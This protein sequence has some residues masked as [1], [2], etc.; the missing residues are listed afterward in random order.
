MKKIH[1]KYR[2]TRNNERLGRPIIILLSVICIVLS[3]P[4]TIKAKDTER[5][6]PDIELGR[7]VFEQIRPHLKFV[8]NPSIRQY[9]E[10][11]GSRITSTLPPN[12]YEFR[13]FPIISKEINAFALSNGYIFITDQLIGACDSEDELA[14][15]L[16]HEI[17]HVIKEHLLN[18]L[19]QKQKIDFATVAIMIMGALLAKD[20]D[21]QEGI[22][23]ISLGMNENLTL[24]YS[25]EQETEAD[26]YGL[27][28]LNQA[29]YE[30]S[31]APQFMEK[32]RLLSQITFYPPPYLSTHPM[33][34]DRLM[35][36]KAL[37]SSLTPPLL[38]PHINDFERIKLWIQ[39][40]TTFTMRMLAELQGSYSK[41]PDNINTIYGLALVNEKLGA[42]EESEKFYLKGIEINP[43]DVDILRDYA[44]FLYKRGKIE[45]AKKRLE[46][47]V[48][49]SNQD[50]ISHYY[51]GRLL[52]D[53]NMP[54][55]A[56]KSL[57]KS[58]EIFPAFEDNYYFLGMAYSKI[59]NE[60][61]SHEYFKK[62]FSLIGN[63]QAAR[64]HAQKRRGTSNNMHE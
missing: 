23:A 31:G 21:L 16:S 45:K 34:V 42:S 3:V 26:T 48:K 27:K 44:I 29:G 18:F 59:G 49:L 52:I 37:Q 58:T 62:Y 2:Q 17:T 35:K 6:P 20:A 60:G 15:V 36:L 63:K 7:E 50:F 64:L 54:E 8:G 56:I 39:M 61:K 28:F 55:D 4:A 9:I 12:K 25:R 24:S 11:V 22:P 33:P 1:L 51:L 43:K 32:L 30:S 57:Q 19:S 53:Q 5:L 46:T 41:T 40:E 10:K 14:F 47:A 13:F 38:Q